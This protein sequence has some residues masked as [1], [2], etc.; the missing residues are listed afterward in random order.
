[1]AFHRLFNDRAGAE[2][3][4]GNSGALTVVAD[5][6]GP[7]ESFGQIHGIT[8]PALNNHGDIA[9]IVD[10]DRGSSG[11]FVG[12]RAVADRVIA[13]GDTLDGATVTSLGS[14]TRASTTPASWRS[15]RPSGTPPR[16]STPAWRSTEPHPSGKEHARVLGR[17]ARPG[18]NAE[19]Y[20]SL[21]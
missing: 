4:T 9:F 16:R 3:V 14:A 19:P 15:R 6:S 7:F 11:I 17:L 20:S 12:P 8:P 2:L 5:T 1:V 18:D 13:T 10:L 21:G